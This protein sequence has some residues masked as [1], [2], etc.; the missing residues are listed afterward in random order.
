MIRTASVLLAAPLALLLA[1]ACATGPA[2]TPAQAAETARITY[3]STMCF[4]TCPIIDATLAADGT[5][6][7]TGKAEPGSTVTVTFPD[8]TTAEVTAG[9]DGV[10][11]AT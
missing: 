7:I 6:T 8:G 9:K 5:L 2:S 3:A 4:G 10:F 11:S 1:T